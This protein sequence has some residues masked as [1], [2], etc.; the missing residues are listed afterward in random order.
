MQALHGGRAR[1][2]EVVDPLLELLNCHAF[3]AI[4]AAMVGRRSARG[5]LSGCQ[6]PP[7]L[8]D[9]DWVDD[10]TPLAL[11]RLHLAS[12]VRPLAVALGP[13]VLEPMI[14]AVDEL[15]E[16]PRVGAALLVEQ[17]LRRLGELAR[18]ARPPILLGPQVGLDLPE[19]GVVERG[20][21]R[22]L[23]GAAPLLLLRQQVRDRDDQHA[24][25]AHDDV[26]GLS[27]VVADVVDDATEL[28]AVALVP[29]F[30]R[31]PWLDGLVLAVG[32]QLVEGGHRPQPHA[33]R[34]LAVDEDGR[35][36]VGVLV[37]VPALEGGLE[38]RV[39]D[40]LEREQ[41]IR[42]Q[43]VVGHLRGAV[44]ED[45]GVYVVGGLLAAEAHDVRARQQVPPL[46]HRRVVV[47]HGHPMLTHQL[48]VVAQR[49]RRRDGR[50][51]RAC[52][53]L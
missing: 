40:L 8:R 47:I 29:L 41:R 4:V 53:H 43:R 7:L 44:C 49:E 20:P 9:L 16:A 45:G 2:D 31:E 21:E 27:R 24:A 30:G 33:V 25:R 19:V 6:A 42:R 50:H 28:L 17:R 32:P 51:G 34:G 23:D 14:Q 22:Q 46:L 36:V 18:D 15:L 13:L 3:V 39:V 38:G 1:L 11:G 10:V 5:H 12:P 52:V 37:L 35:V 48:R 26:E